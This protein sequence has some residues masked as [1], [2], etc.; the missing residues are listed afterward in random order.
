MQH[1]V[2]Y[3]SGKKV[4]RFCLVK[5]KGCVETA[6]PHWLV[7]LEQLLC[8]S[9]SSSKSMGWNIRHDWHFNPLYKKKASVMSF[10]S[11]PLFVHVHVK[12]SV[13]KYDLNFCL[14]CDSEFSNC[15]FTHLFQTVLLKALSCLMLTGTSKDKKL[16]VQLRL[17][18]IIWSHLKW[19]Q[20]LSTR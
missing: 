16:K 18:P 20:I 5:Q 1:Q 15:V 10:S 14:Q 8:S 17:Q 7:V 11:T 4:F 6:V 12:P 3:N 9:P 19:S 2:I 13:Y